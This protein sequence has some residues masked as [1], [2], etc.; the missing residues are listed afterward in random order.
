MALTRIR[1][2]EKEPGVL[3]SK[4]M[5][6]TTDVVQVSLDLVH[7]SATYTFKRDGSKVATKLKSKTKVNALIEVKNHLRGLGVNIFDEV[8]NKRLKL[9]GSEADKSIVTKE[10]SNDQG[11][12]HLPNQVL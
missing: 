1:Y 12:N 6:T 5:L 3:I 4:E 11:N 10:V 7:M 8:R 9:S 2:T